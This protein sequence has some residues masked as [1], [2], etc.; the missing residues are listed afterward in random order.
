MTDLRPC[1]F[2]G[3]SAQIEQLPSYPEYVKSKSWVVGCDG[4]YGILCPGYI[5]KC[6]PFYVTKNQAM[7]YWNHR[8]QIAEER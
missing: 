8:A 6:T 3:E 7:D 2:C 1:P 4:K 5:W